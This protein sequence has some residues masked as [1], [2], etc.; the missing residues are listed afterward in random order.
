MV[1][2]FSPYQRK[3]SKSGHSVLDHHGY[4]KV[5]FYGT[6]ADA[7]VLAVQP[8]PRL[9]FPSVAAQYELTTPRDEKILGNYRFAPWQAQTLKVGG[10]LPVKYYAPDLRLVLPRIAITPLM[11]GLYG[12][13]LLALV[14]AA[15]SIC[16]ILRNKS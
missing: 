13:N 9:L 3:R 16:R 4:K 14:I 10:D 8:E 7:T 15:F 2:V 1:M 6:E 11:V 12:L 5:Y